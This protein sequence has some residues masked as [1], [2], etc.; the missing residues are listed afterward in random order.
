MAYLYF[1]VSPLIHTAPSEAMQAFFS[2][3]IP[4][5]V[6]VLLALL[7]LAD[8]LRRRRGVLWLETSELWFLL[9]FGYMLVAGIFLSIPLM[10]R[11]VQDE[12]GMIKSLKQ[13][14]MIGLALAFYFTTRRL[15]FRVSHPTLRRALGYTL[16]FLGIY[17]LLEYVKYVVGIS[18]VLPIEPLLHP[19]SPESPY[20]TFSQRLRLTTPE[21]SMGAPYL[22]IYGALY[23]Y[24]VLAERRKGWGP[25]LLLA[26]VFLLL[27]VMGSKGALLGFILAF[28]LS[29]WTLSFVAPQ[30]SRR[31]HILLLGLLAFA[32]LVPLS[33]LSRTGQFL[34]QTGIYENTVLTRAVEMAVGIQLFLNHPLWG[35]GSGN[36][37]FY[38]HEYLN[39]VG[40]VSQEIFW[41]LKGEATDV[42]IGYK[43]LFI[44]VLAE[45]GLI[46]VTLFLGFLFFVFRWLLRA[47][48]IR[49][50]EGILLFVFFFILITMQYTDG[51]NR[52]YW[53]V[54]L[55]LVQALAQ[56][57]VQE[58][59]E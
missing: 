35:I 41:M 44:A 6:T 34:L 16:L 37:V 4:A 25:F 12:H 27:L 28:F 30:R 8:E 23:L 10:E 26:G 19:R 9:F 38:F 2:I 45:G 55:G 1:L 13:S 32:V 14:T 57:A 18:G 20:G 24:L 11:V 40:I 49:P 43:N 47:L 29:L 3:V 17:G 46:G 39:R 21:P 58:A 5:F 54:G 36:L 53:W 22:V 52:V 33:L 42:S 7:F 50:R 31:G 51:Y 15:V 56:Q 48:K 59:A